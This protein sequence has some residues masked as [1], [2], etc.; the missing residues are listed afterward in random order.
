MPDI[1]IGKQARDL[2]K[3]VQH[4]ALQGHAGIVMGYAAVL[5]EELERAIKLKMRPLSKSMDKDLFDG[6]YAP[7]STFAAKIDVA[8]ALDITTTQIHEDLNRIRLIRNNFAHSKQ[9]LNLEVEPIRSLFGALR[10]PS[11]TKTKPLEIFAE[12]VV[13]IDDY[14][15][16]FLARM[17]V[18]EGLRLFA[19]KKTGV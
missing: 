9:V 4:V 5:E 12:C 7:I 6:R 19:Q 16:A 17:G 18:T 2:I 8:Y 14:L 3:A 10:K 15:E 13:A 1:D 11:T